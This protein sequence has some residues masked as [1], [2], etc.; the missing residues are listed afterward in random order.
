MAQENIR[1]YE[2]GHGL[3]NMVSLYLFGGKFFDYDDSY[4]YYDIDVDKILLYKKSDDEY[5]I[6]Y[7]DVKKEEC[8]T[9][10]IKNNEF[11][12]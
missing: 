10:T 7:N 3:Y 8:C 2:Y 9:I 6:S 12:M 5:V 4:N 11:F 1:F